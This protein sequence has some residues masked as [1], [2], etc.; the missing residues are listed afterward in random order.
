MSVFAFRFVQENVYKLKCTLRCTL[1]ATAV[2]RLRNILLKLI[3]ELILE[4]ILEPILELLQIM[5]TAAAYL[6]LAAGEPLP[7]K[8]AAP[9]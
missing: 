4:P 8:Y 9:K 3:L 6:Q 5:S 1:P 7:K 2:C